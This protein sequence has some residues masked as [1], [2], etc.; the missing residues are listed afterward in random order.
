MKAF[1]DRRAKIERERDQEQT[2]K[3]RQKS[4]FSVLFISEK[5]LR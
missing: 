4:Q 5:G 3:K 2:T 1:L